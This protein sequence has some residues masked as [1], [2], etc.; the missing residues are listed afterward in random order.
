MKKLMILGASILQVPAIIKAKDMGLSVIALDMNPNAV[1]LKI[2]GIIPEVIS[3][4]D[5]DRVLECAKKHNIDGIMTIAS[6]M[7]MQTVAKVCKELGLNGISEDA[8]LK[9]TNK[10]YMMDAL[11]SYKVPI[12]LYYKVFTFEEY[13]K[14]VHSIIE[15]GCKCIS[16]P[17]DNS[18]SRGVTLISEGIDL[19]K[20]YQY[21]IKNSR[22]GEVV[23]EEYL[24][25]PEVSVETLAVD[26][27]VS[28]IQI[29]DKCT[30]GSPFFVETE[31]SQPSI[32]D[33]NIKKR[34]A[35]VAVDANKAIGI[36]NGPSHT[37]I[38]ITKDGPKI[39]EIGARLGGDCITSHLVPLST[40]VDMVEYSI[41][42]ALGEKPS[43]SKLWNRGA[44]IKYLI[45]KPGIIKKIKGVDEA[46]HIKGVKQVSILKGIND[47]VM[48]VRNSTDR[49]GFVICEAET[50][51][52]AQTIADKATKIIK[53]ETLQ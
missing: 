4:I 19:H 48:D 8:A 3:T 45:P 24:E 21:S 7:P 39:V 10:A 27:E 5:T 37:E 15:K 32:L 6:D 17:A 16:K 29:T 43:I 1:G 12:P 28:I 2:E 18:G 51:I 23:V 49:T 38:R 25:G 9:A 35:Q 33:N 34:I 53:I 31:H 36:T 44:C 11:K 41:R 20:E 30:S 50:P 26:G 13:K 47:R 40:G 46:K 22:S 14:A 42:I 52:L